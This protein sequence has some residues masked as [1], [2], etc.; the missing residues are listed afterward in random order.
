MSIAATQPPVTNEVLLLEMRHLR[1]DFERAEQD[2]RKIEEER[3][4]AEEETQRRLRSVEDDR[5]M[6]RAII[7]LAGFVGFGTLIWL[8][9]TLLSSAGP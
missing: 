9:R 3:K 1:T 5:L 4:R 7:A 6:A 8:A 2:R